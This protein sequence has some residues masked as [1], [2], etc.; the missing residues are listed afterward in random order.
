LAARCAKHFAR[1]AAACAAEAATAAATASATLLTLTGRTAI[2][3]TIRLI[4]E[5]FHSEELLFAA[6][7]H[8]LT[9]TIDAVQVFILI[10]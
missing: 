10:H 1:C 9:R 4:L 5:A 3:A 6:R 2:G 7:K 8:E